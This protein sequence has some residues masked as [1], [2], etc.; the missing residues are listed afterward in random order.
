MRIKAALLMVAGLAVIATTR[1]LPA[2][3]VS[4]RGR[5][6]RSVP[7]YGIVPAANICVTVNNQY[8]G[9]SRPACTGT[10]G[11]FVLGEIPGGSYN[12]EI[13]VSGPPSPARA[14]D[15]AYTIQVALR[16]QAV[17]DLPPVT[18]P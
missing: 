12:L 17:V 10:D 3:V 14:P 2:Q 18:L 15:L 11:M 9:R 7:S 5:I 13:W 6:Q 8:R 4:I 16:G 1:A